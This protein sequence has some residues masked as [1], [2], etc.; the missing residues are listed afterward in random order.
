MFEKG[1]DASNERRKKVIDNATTLK[2]TT[3]SVNRMLKLSY[4]IIHQP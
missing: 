4:R 3:K 2:V 1:R